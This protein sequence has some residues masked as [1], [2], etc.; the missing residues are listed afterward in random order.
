MPRKKGFTLIE[1]L[2]V[3]AIVAMLLSLVAPRY[4]RQADKAKEAV[5]RENLS[6]LRLALDQYYSDK[7]RYPERLDLLVH[8]RYLR[9]LPIDPITD[10]NTTWQA[11]VL[12]EEGRSG[13]YDVK[14]GAQGKGID[15]T[16]YSTW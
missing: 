4:M 13:I 16:A 8:E 9:R 14:S 5:L 12:E 11:V 2:V 3:M 7:G 6:A 15:K 10:R 1:L